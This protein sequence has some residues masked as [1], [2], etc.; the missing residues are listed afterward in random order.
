MGKSVFTAA[1]GLLLLVFLT[2]AHAGEVAIYTGSVGWIDYYLANEQAQICANRL[3]NAGIPCVRYQYSSDEAAL[4]TWVSRATRNGAVDVLVLYGYVPSSIYPAGNA[5]P[6]GSIAELFIESTDG[7]A[8]INHA[9]Y[10]FYVSS[11]NNDVGGL[12]NMMDIPGIELM[13][14]NNTAVFVTN[15]G[16]E[17]A[18]NLA[19]F[20]SERPFPIDQL[21]GNWFVEASLA[22]NIEGT[23][24]DPIIVRDGDRGR[25]IPLYQTDW[26]NDPKGAVAAEVIAW[27]MGVELRP[28]TALRLSGSTTALTGRPLMLTL[29]VVDDTGS[30]TPTPDAV[31][32]NLASGSATGAF[33][34]VF[35]GSYD[36]TV[37]SVTIPAGERSA[38]VLYYRETSAGLVTL[39]VTA[40]GLTYG[41]ITVNVLQDV[42]VGPGEVAIYTGALS[43]ISREAADA[44]AQICIDKLNIL[45]IKSTLFAST[46]NDAAL[47]TW[48]STAR[49]NGKLDVLVLY[50]YVP[51]SIYPAGNAM[52]DNSI[53]ERFIESTDGDT[54]IN[55]ADYMFFV[56][57]TNNDAGGLQNMMDIY[58]TMWDDNTP[59]AVTGQGRAI[60]PS[61]TSFLT[62]RP[63]HVDELAGEWFVEASLAQN[64]AGT[65]ADPIIVRDGIRGR[66]I[67]AYQT[68][69]GIDPKG[70]VTA[71][72]IAWLHG[73]DLGAAASVGLVGWTGGVRGRPLKLEAQMQNVLGAALPV[74]VPATVNLQTDSP[75]GAFDI[76]ANGSFDGTV[77]SVTIAAGRSSAEFYYKDTAVGTS[78]LTGS[79]AGLADG[80][81]AVKMWEQSFAPPGEVAIFTGMVDWIDSRL[82]KQQAQI[83][84]NRLAGAGIPY[85]WYQNASNETA[86]AQ[87]MTAATNNG[88]ADVLVLYGA[89][90]TTI[91]PT[92]NTWPNGSVAELFIESTDGDA[93]INHGDWM[94]FISS[95]NFNYEA[96]LQNMMDIPSIELWDDFDAPMVVTDTGREIAPSLTDFP[97]DRPLPIDQLAGDWYVEASLAQN[98]AGTRADPIVVRDGDRGRLI[99][100]YQTEYQDDPKGAVAAEVIA[101]LMSTPLRPKNLVLSGSATAVTGTPVRLSLKLLDDAGIPTRSPNALTVNLASDSA[102]GAFDTVW[103][104]SYDG[105]VASVTIPAGEMSSGAFYYRTGLAESVTLSAIAPDLADGK[106][107]VNVLQGA[108]VVPGEV[109]I[110]TGSISWIEPDDAAAQAEICVDKLNI[111]GITNTW[112]R[113]AADEGALADWVSAATVNGKMDVLVLYGC[114][115]TTIY[116]TGNAMPDESL[117]E[118]FIESTDGDAIIYHADYMFWVTSLEPV[119]LYNEIAGLQ[120]MMD[121]PDIELFDDFDAPMVVTDQGAAVAPSLADFLSDFPFPVDQLTGNWFVEAALAQNAAGTRADPIIL[122][123]GNHG[124]LIPAFPTEFQD[125]PK[126]AVAAEIIAWLMARPMPPTA[127]FTADLR[128]GKAPFDVSFDASASEGMIVSYAWD[129]GDATTG[130]GVAVTHTF[131]NETGSTVPYVVTLTVTSDRGLMGQAHTTISVEPA[132]ILFVRGDINVSDTF[133]IAD[134]ICLL[135]YLF[136]MPG[137]TCK[138]N[139]PHCLESAD[140]NDS[141]GVDIADTIYLINY[142]FALKAPPLAPWPDCGADPQLEGH[143]PLG[144]ERFEL[145][146]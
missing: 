60:A 133:D 25:L 48:V 68:A 85:V 118:I 57:S 103:E 72:I 122:R 41:E 19:D 90:P 143:L 105:T 125:D 111:L 1:G 61:L 73:F 116:P 56:S 107:T 11:T 18:P 31:T 94:F 112:F 58:I 47:A 119:E 70:A 52:P 21:A 35:R 102:Y 45:G 6:D 71:E 110:Y 51:S 136:G 80:T 140:V 124:R 82:A 81:L 44:Q 83:C 89:V 29:R 95:P 50:G 24:A 43:W 139:V 14:D 123:D 2:S 97:T 65:R 121:I 9:D 42:P 126:G 78:V 30:P 138:V 15:T 91:Y 5:M 87:W 109:A 86:L 10:L 142:L 26:H 96:G 59:V 115:P 104:G 93:I 36:G 63:F 67:P 20:P 137:E 27:L 127:S 135:S 75:T 131:Q 144:C 12:Q 84:V 114:V 146:E 130:S 13:D 66:L 92:G 132:D 106:L 55:H 4:A 98:A 129:F 28:P 100:L 33:D 38:T 88:K 8:I 64:A 39:S 23:R 16:R 108:P 49:N 22:Q 69:D 54:I 62:D 32:V 113:N 40:P 7:D 145:C 120:N 53:A 76:A 3:N 37:T 74:D 134:A 79:A 77:T 101:W 17:I 46:S 141:G 34:T 117:A 128:S 99:P